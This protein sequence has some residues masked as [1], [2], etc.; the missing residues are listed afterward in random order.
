MKD[1]QDCGCPGRLISG[2]TSDRLISKTQK[3]RLKEAGWDGGPVRA[4]IAAAK[5]G[6]DKFACSVIR[7]IEYPHNPT[8]G[9]QRVEQRKGI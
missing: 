6:G 5:S 7:F 4:L 8:L 1:L 2:R 3:I 9:N